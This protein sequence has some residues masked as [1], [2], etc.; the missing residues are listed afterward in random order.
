MNKPTT[1]KEIAEELADAMEDALATYQGRVKAIKRIESALELA[2]KQRLA[3]LAQTK[4]A[5]K[6]ESTTQ[7]GLFFWA[8]QFGRAWTVVR[9]VTGYPETEACDDWF[10]SEKDAM[11]VA[12]RL[13]KG[14]EV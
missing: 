8:E 3:D 13:A 10:A 11:E 5:T 14:E 6:F 7:P 1:W 2:V 12:E 9:Q 4:E